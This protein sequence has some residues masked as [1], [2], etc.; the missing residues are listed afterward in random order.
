MEILLQAI[1][2]KYSYDIYLIL[3]V[4]YLISMLHAES[5]FTEINLV[6]IHE[7]TRG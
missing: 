7:F 1:F 5:G 3:Y 4:V 6:A 2:E